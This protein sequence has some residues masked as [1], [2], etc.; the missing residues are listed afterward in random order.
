MAEHK[1]QAVKLKTTMVAG[2]SVLDE[3]QV[4]YAARQIDEYIQKKNPK[5]LMML[6]HDVRYFTVFDMK[7]SLVKTSMG[8]QILDFAEK[9]VSPVYGG[10]KL[11][12]AESTM[13]AVEIW[14]GETCFILFDYTDGVV[15]L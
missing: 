11:I 12:D 14:C 4:E 8:K 15:Q 3:V 7:G 10:L 13:G 9:Y 5:Y 2:L 6:N 1:I